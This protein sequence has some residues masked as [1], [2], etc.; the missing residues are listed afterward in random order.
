MRIALGTIEVVPLGPIH[1]LAFAPCVIT[2][3]DESGEDQLRGALS[4][5]L[6]KSTG[7][8]KVLHGHASVRVPEDDEED[9]E[10]GGDTLPAASAARLQGQGEALARSEPSERWPFV[11]SSPRR[12]RAV[13]R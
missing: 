5:V 6:E 8:W 4:L 2:L 3:R 10:E 1:V 13:T 7:K 12:L 11:P 9:P